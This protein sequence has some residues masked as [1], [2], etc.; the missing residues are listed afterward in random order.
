MAMANSC[1]YSCEQNRRLIV[2][3]RTFLAAAPLAA[4]GLASAR[5]SSQG[6]SPALPPLSPSLPGTQFYPDVEAGDRP[7]GASFATRSEVFG[8]NGAAASS[9]PLATLAGIEILKRGGSA[10][11]AAIAMN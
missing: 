4:V 3:R 10:A 7:V 9:H 2:K 5:G 11:D 6:T 8:R 1:G